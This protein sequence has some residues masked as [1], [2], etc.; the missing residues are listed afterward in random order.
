MFTQGVCVVLCEGAN[1]DDFLI[2][3][4]ERPRRRTIGKRKAA[5]GRRWEKTKAR[6]C[7][8]AIEITVAAVER[9]ERR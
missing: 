1:S 5:D 8:Q 3:A 9:I 6:E 4:A 7:E 2:V